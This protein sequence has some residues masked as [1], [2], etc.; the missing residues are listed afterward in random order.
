MV[1]RVLR[2]S[3]VEKVHAV[4]VDGHSREHEHDD[5]GTS[6]VNTE[7]SVGV[8]KSFNFYLLGG[9]G[10]EQ[11]QPGDYLYGNMN[12]VEPNTI[13]GGQWGLLRVHPEGTNASIQPLTKSA[14]SLKNVTAKPLITKEP[15]PV[16]VKGD[17]NDIAG[18]DFGDA[19]LAAQALTGLEQLTPLQITA[20]D[21]NGNGALD[22]GDVL[23]ILQ[24][25]AGLRIL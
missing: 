20:A 18:L 16:P 1:V 14:E 24:A 2:P 9:A 5:P 3:D 10:G 11:Q 22:V 23:F 19:L 4:G 25:V 6:I 12:H 13:Q 7:G 17:V 21:V 15:A 8:G